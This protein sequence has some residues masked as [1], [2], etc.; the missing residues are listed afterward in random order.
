MLLW[1]LDLY[2][3]C[4]KV[5]FLK[6]P[7][8]VGTGERGQQTQQLMGQAPREKTPP[9]FSQAALPW[10]STSWALG[11][12]APMVMWPGTRSF[13]WVVI[14]L[15]TPSPSGP[16]QR[17]GCVLLLGFLCLDPLPT[18]LPAAHAV[19]PLTFQPPPACL[20]LPLG[21]TLLLSQLACA[22]LLPPPSRSEHSILLLPLGPSAN[23]LSPH[24][25]LDQRELCFCPL[26]AL[27]W[28]VGKLVRDYFLATGF[29]SL[30]SFLSFW[31]LLVGFLYFFPVQA[32]A[33][34]HLVLST[35]HHIP[36]SK[37]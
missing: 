24:F 6:V 23:T 20:L 13:A 30:K 36:P 8:W 9:S 28:I 18:P 7:N 34:S 21:A 5:V 16:H 1:I 25:Q 3:F 31:I 15:A 37:T 35:S 29:Y 14:P 17:D 12:A 19:L 4:P 2:T 11:T 32:Q 26:A 10:Q 27:A 33:H 22:L